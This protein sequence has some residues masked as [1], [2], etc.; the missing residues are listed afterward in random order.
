MSAS[1]DIT[2]RQAL[3]RL[4]RLCVRA[5]HCTAELRRRLHS[6]HIAPSDADVIMQSLIDRRFVDDTRFATA[7]VRDRYRFSAWG[8][9]KILAQMRLRGIDADTA[10]AALAVID[11]PTYIRILA[12]LLRA[13]ARSMPE[14]NTFEARQRLLS[15]AIGRGYEATL[16]LRLIDRLFPKE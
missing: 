16:A 15:Y 5:E 4:E 6:W 1:R 12:R 3:E 9:R 10:A 13:R 8:R 14:P 7:F 2:P 11:T